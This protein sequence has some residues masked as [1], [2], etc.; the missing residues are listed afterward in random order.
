MKMKGSPLG[1]LRRHLSASRRSIDSQMHH[2]VVLVQG[3]TWIRGVTWSLILTAGFGLGWL[4]LARTEE[5]IVVQ[6]KLE[7]EGDVKEIQLPVGGVVKKILVEAGDRVDKGQ[8]LI[9]LDQEVSTEQLRSLSTR[10]RQ[11]EAQ[12]VQ[13]QQL[14]DQQIQTTKEQLEL[15]RK[16]LG[17]L[18]S[19]QSLGATSEFQYLQQ[20]TAVQKLLGDLSKIALDGRRQVLI[21]EQELAQLRA[22]SAQA[23]VS[24]RYQSLRSP[25]AGTVFDLKPTTIGFV[26]QT[27][28]PVLKIVPLNRLEADVEVPSD[29]IGFVRVG[30]QADISIDSF[31]ASDFGVLNGMVDSIGSDALPPDQQKQRTGYAFPVTIGLKEQSLKLAN[32]RS[33]PLQVGMSLTAN[34]KLRSVSYLQLLLNTF[35]SKADSLRE[36]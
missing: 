20:K 4:A 36:L 13:T 9:Q 1:F 11:K 2:G 6:G 24:L 25:V 8:V 5:V 17:K 18:E 16:I 3:N 12:I 10:I 29:K 22:E 30:M 27:S 32:G 28:Q 15:D 7:P 26:A 23:S 34:I 33:L 35:R 31:P 19:L 21:L 14:T